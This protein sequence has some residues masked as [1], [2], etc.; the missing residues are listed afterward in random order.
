[1]FKRLISVGLLCLG[2]GS[3]YGQG[4]G[5]QAP[6]PDTPLKIIVF[7]GGWNLPIWAAQR[8]GF[9][10]QNKLAVELVYTPNSVKL[11]TGLLAG[12]YD[13]AFAGIDNVIAYQEGQGEVPVQSPDLFAFLGGDNGLLS[14]VSAPAIKSAKDLKGKSLSVDAM[15]TGFAFVL[16]DYVARSGLAEGD[17]TYTRAGST[18]NRYQGLVDGKTDATLLRTPFDLVAREKGFN[19]LAEGP[20]LGDFQG[21]VGVTT[22]RWAAKNEDV[23][24]RFIRA[25]RAGLDW[26]HVDANRP[27]SEALL[28]ANTSDMSPAL[29]KSA[30]SQLIG[31][32]LTRDASINLSGI[33]N[34]LALR[35]RFGTPNKT[36]TD[37]AKYVD[38][39]YL[40]KAAAKP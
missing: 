14:V 27:I 8:Q 16:R 13:L 29:A 23:L 12:D 22:R 26:I 39:Q 36:L 38:M 6:P 9:F 24:L 4:A 1:V 17:V 18:A 11:V 3:A 15:T 30:L 37:P 34:V 25:Y 32:G 2:F 5:P 35:S 10:K 33:G 28:V 31:G 20:A 19:V 40:G 21:T 7:D